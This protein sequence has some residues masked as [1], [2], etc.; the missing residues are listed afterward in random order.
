MII[1]KYTANNSFYA[2]VEID[3]IRNEYRSKTELTDE[4]WLDL[5]NRYIAYQKEM[6]LLREQEEQQQ[7]ESET[8]IGE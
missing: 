8:Q 5:A 1:Q 3:G 7:T 4:Q 2:I 6:A